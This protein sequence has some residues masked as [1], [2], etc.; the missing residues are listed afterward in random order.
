MTAILTKLF[1]KL[2]PD[3]PQRQYMSHPTRMGRSAWLASLP[4]NPTALSHPDL[5]ADYDAAYRRE[6]RD[7]QDARRG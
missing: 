3:E 2:G 6:T 4:R 5:Q 7:C 1:A